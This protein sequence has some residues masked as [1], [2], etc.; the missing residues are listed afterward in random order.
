LLN[1]ILRQF[2]SA[3][4]FSAF[5]VLCVLLLPTIEHGNSMSVENNV[6]FLLEIVFEYF[7]I[8]FLQQLKAESEE[9][10]DG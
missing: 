9:F 8:G 3:T 2:N 10:C 7:F 4:S 5:S 6:D 1:A